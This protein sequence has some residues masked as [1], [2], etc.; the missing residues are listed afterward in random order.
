MANLAVPFAGR[1]VSRLFARPLLRS[2]VAPLRSSIF[3]RNFADQTSQSPQNLNS[4]TGLAAE[5]LAQKTGQT[6]VTKATVPRNPKKPARAPGSDNRKWKIWAFSCGF[7][8]STCVGSVMYFGRPF[9]GEEEAPFS[10]LN[11]LS[12]HI[13]RMKKRIH[14]FEEFFSNPA[15]D[16]LL[17][18]PLPEPYQR[19]L[20]LVINLDETLVYSTW[21]KQHGWRTAKRPGV[22]YFLAYLSQFYEIV[23]FTSQQAF[24]AIPIVEKLDPYNYAMYKLFREATR[25]ANGK[26][27][28]DLSCLNR[29]LSKVIIM[30][31]NPDS[32]SLQPENAIPMKPWKGD[33]ND[34][35]LLDMIPFL[36]ALALT[37][38]QDVRPTLKSFENTDIP[39]EYARRERLWDEKLRREWEEEKK[40]RSEKRGLGSLLGGLSGHS[41]GEQEERPPESYL[42]ML[43]RQHRE[44][45]AREHEQMQAAVE[46][47]WRQQREQ[48]E[49]QMKEMKLT[50]WQLMTQGVPPPVGGLGSEPQK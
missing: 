47:E 19:P 12:A 25:Y 1:V 17:P 21:D 6:T 10:N 7:L 20:T 11:T 18:D 3:S 40:K 4:V 38:I 35:G 44:T 5:A 2:P 33:P 22:D 23:I 49:K 36:E 32:Y 13:Q 9:E 16:K 41:A 31:S 42:Q 50:A 45:F 37:G 15:W 48:Q 30:D 8:V 14:D 29:D 46:E 28:K 34:T 26:V 27:V 24:T 39:I 43:R